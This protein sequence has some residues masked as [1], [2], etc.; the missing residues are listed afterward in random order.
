MNGRCHQQLEHESHRSV[1]A[2][3]LEHNHTVFM[4]WA[5]LQWTIKWAELSS[6]LSFSAGHPQHQNPFFI[7]TICIKLT[8]QTL[9]RALGN[10][11]THDSTSSKT[12]EFYA[13]FPGLILGVVVHQTHRCPNTLFRFRTY[14]TSE[15]L[16]GQQEPITCNQYRPLGSHYPDMCGE[17]KYVYACQCDAGSQMKYCDKAKKE[18]NGTGMVACGSGVPPGD[19]VVHLPN[20]RCP[21]HREDP[22]P[23]PTYVWK[24]VIERQNAAARKG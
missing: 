6:L 23:D 2:S 7:N 14:I 8:R 18:P 20:N 13:R 17:R 24:D 11:T 22:P 10:K 1:T 21:K 9:T 15:T 16:S 4:T 5:G 12:N 3:T 19:A